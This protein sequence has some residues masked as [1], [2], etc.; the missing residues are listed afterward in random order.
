[1]R[2]GPGGRRRRSRSTRTGGAGGAAGGGCSA[3]E[4]EVSE[5]ESRPAL[6]AFLQVV[7]LEAELS[8]QHDDDAT[9]DAVWEPRRRAHVFLRQALLAY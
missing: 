7:E 2:G 4:A 3:L 1:M 5:E 9:A 8:Q 6:G